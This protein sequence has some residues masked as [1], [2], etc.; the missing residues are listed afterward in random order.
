MVLYMESNRLTTQTGTSRASGVP[1]ATK[2]VAESSNSPIAK[3]SSL[4]R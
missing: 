4:P 3:Y 2:M 1:E